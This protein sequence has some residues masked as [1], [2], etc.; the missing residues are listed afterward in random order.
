M[1]K[2]NVNSNHPITP[3]S[4]EYMTIKKYVS[5]HS[6]DRDIIKYPNSSLFDIEL[7]QDYL[8]VV[9]IRLESWS[10]PSNYYCFSKDN[11]NILLSFYI[12]EIYDPYLITSNLETAIQSALL[13]H[14]TTPYNAFI[15]EGFYNP[16][17]MANEL[18]NKMNYIVSVYISSYLETYN[19]I[20]G[21]NVGDLEYLSQSDIDSFNSY[22]NTG[23]G[24]YEEFVVVYNVVGQKLWFGNR[25]SGFNIRP[26]SPTI[27]GL[28]NNTEFTQ[29]LC[30]QHLV[31]PQYLNGNNVRNENT[32]Q[33]LCFNLGF[34][35]D[36]VNSS[37]LP[38][39]D[40]YRF[41]YGDVKYPYDNGFWLRPDPNKVGSQVYYLTTPCQINFMGPSY[42]YLELD[43]LNHIDEINPYALTNFTKTTN[44]TNSRVNSAFAKLGVL[45]APITEF[46]DNGYVPYKFYNPPAERIRKL[47][48]RIRYHNN[49]L[50]NFGS[51]SFSFVL[52]FTLLTPQ[53]LTQMSTV[54]F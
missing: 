15:E 14:K 5:I 24:G 46:Y 45:S 9:K 35:K 53:K 12:T 6:E 21:Y 28:F 8:N 16:P 36:Q 4:Q 40:S 17:Q 49:M 47:K 30:E 31:Y 52:E 18:T 1:S 54:Q 22:K 44:E 32:N 13:A 23:T 19:T 42:I 26:S 11:F 27:S 33:G 29:I 41:Y 39:G 7:P 43:G 37:S 38:V 3:N 48:V 20:N 50:V 34:L 10:F 2:F 25:S 51:F